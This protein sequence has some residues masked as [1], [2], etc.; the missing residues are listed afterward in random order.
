MKIFKALWIF[1][2]FFSFSQFAFADCPVNLQCGQQLQL[3]WS[4]VGTVIDCQVTSPGG[5]P[6]AGTCSSNG[7][8]SSNVPVQS[9]LYVFSATNQITGGTIQ[10]S[11]Q[12]T[13]PSP[14]DCGSG[15]YDISAAPTPVQVCSPNTSGSS[16]I[17]WVA[18]AGQS[19]A[20]EVNGNGQ[21]P[22]F[23][24]GTGSGS[25]DA[26]WIVAGQTYTF[27][28]Y[29][30]T[31]GVLELKDS[32]T[33]TTTNA[34]CTSASGFKCSSYQCIACG[35]STGVTCNG[36]GSSCSAVAQS[37][38]ETCGDGS[39]TPGE[40]CDDG[41]VANNDGCSNVC[42]IESPTQSV[43]LGWTT[44]APHA[45]AG[46]TIQLAS[47]ATS[48][49]K[50]IY[51][52]TTGTVSSCSIYQ[53]IS[54]SSS[55][56]SVYSIP[57][58][59]VAGG[60][61][62]LTGLTANSYEFE[63]FCSGGSGIAA[64]G[65][66]LTVAPASTAT[67]AVGFNVV[68]NSITEPTKTISSGQTTNLYYGVENV[69]AN[70]CTITQNPTGGVAAG[71]APT[72]STQTFQSGSRT[73]P[74][75][76]VSGVTS[77]T[78]TMTCTRTSGG[79]ITSNV[80]TLSMTPVGQSVSCT[81]SPQNI[82]ATF[83]WSG[84]GFSQPSETRCTVDGVLGAKGVL[85]GSFVRSSVG[86][87][88]V[89]CAN[90]AQTA[91]ANCVAQ[92]PPA[93]TLDAACLTSPTVPVVRSGQQFT[94]NVPFTNTG[95]KIWNPGL[96]TYLT[97]SSSSLAAWNNLTQTL[98]STISGTPTSGIFSPSFILTAPFVLTPT[99]YTLSFRMNENAVAF[100]SLCTVN[101]SSGSV[102][103]VSPPRCSDGVDNDIDGLTDCT[104]GSEDPG[105]YP[106]GNGG[107]GACNPQDD[108]ENDATGA[109][110]RISANP[111]LVR[112]G[113]ASEIS[114]EVSGCTSLTKGDPVSWELLRDGNSIGVS[115]AEDSGGEQK[116]PVSDIQNKTTFT[117][118]CGGT[119]RSATISVIKI[120]EF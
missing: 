119:S 78:Y 31:G 3:N 47:G 120:G 62:L 92:N 40:Q 104:S 81:P 34:G 33:V 111:Q 32:V 30:T 59:S 9:G 115:G 23:A 110:L 90:G 53:R 49:T 74:W 76:A 43:D 56:T 28:L 65:I 29:R 2:I 67:A 84:S 22:Y 14:A 27:D 16:N 4:S 66:T 64:S 112:Q 5:N 70:T 85:S 95:S 89:S 51:W 11:C 38:E 42:T 20:I 61:R 96:A 25:S 1:I 80:A 118:S 63:L 103:T 55:W 45:N 58:G 75:G 21:A 13:V 46:G 93:E 44:P 94:V 50:Q 8:T 109:V 116:Y 24:T 18:P 10:S 87:Y 106:D 17:S 99:N 72:T 97:R 68:G 101:A 100:G 60:S 86:T 108:D 19:V 36:S 69:V 71:S 88:T 48:T 113:G 41:N 114:Y 73:V 102:V 26:N 54:P 82:P 77:F 6:I 52:T 37:C 57:S 79:T 39:Q 15:T 7:W 107:G 105:C 117:L 98:V 35:G 12:V 83:N 91:S